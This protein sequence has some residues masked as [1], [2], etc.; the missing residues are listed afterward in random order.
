MKNTWRIEQEPNG[1]SLYRNRRI[2][3]YEYPDI[4]EAAA[5]V[6]RKDGKGVKILVVAIDGRTHTVTT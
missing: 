4:D 6:R 2:Y 1:W 3:A 5:T